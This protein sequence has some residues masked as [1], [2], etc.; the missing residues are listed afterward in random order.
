MTVRDKL[1]DAIREA[2]QRDDRG[3]LCVL[4]LIQTTIRDRDQAHCLGHGERI[5]A[6]E[7]ALLLTKMIKQR[8]A[9]VALEREANNSEVGAR[10]EREIEVIREFMPPLMDDCSL[11]RACSQVVSELG[12]A[13]LRDVGRTLS[14]LK[15]RYPG[16]LNLHRAGGVLK[17][18][19]R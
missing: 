7:V 13:G 8:Q 16:Q 11:R 2:S 5:S 4:R 15:Q 3:R 17:E 6:S 12:A 18:M 14:T 1:Q 19:L 9:Q 10:I